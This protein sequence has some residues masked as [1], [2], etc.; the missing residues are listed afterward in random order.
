MRIVAGANYSIHLHDATCPYIAWKD[1][2]L[3]VGRK[4][5]EACATQ[6]VETFDSPQFNSQ[7]QFSDKRGLVVFG[8]TAVWLLALRS[9]TRPRNLVLPDDSR[10]RFVR[11]LFLYPDTEMIACFT[12]DRWLGGCEFYVAKDGNELEVFNAERA[13]MDGLLDVVMCRERRAFLLQSGSRLRLYG[14]KGDLVSEMDVGIA[15]GIDVGVLSDLSASPDA[16]M[17]AL[18]VHAVEL[19]PVRLILIGLCDRSIVV[20]AED[21][22]N[23]VWSPTGHCVAYIGREASLYVYDVKAMT[24]TLVCRLSSSASTWVEEE[25]AWGWPPMWS[26]NGQILSAVLTC[27]DEAGTREWAD[28]VVD[29]KANAVMVLDELQVPKG[30]SLD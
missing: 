24:S 6:V 9:P 4:P 29:M 3:M 10:H 17:A 25:G 16:T 11:K 30:Y 12:L 28:V 20:I 21:G 7:V 8:C 15:L 14:F 27:M 23:P 19:S 1:D 13:A 5:G 2:V 22:R 18:C 26:P